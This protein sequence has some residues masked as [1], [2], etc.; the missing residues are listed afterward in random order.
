MGGEQGNRW[1]DQYVALRSS[2][3]LGKTWTAPRRIQK[4]PE[5]I[6]ARGETRPHIAFGN[7]GEIYI[8]YTSTIAMPH[9]GEIRFVRSTD[10]GQTFSAPVTVHARIGTSL[11]IAL[12][13][14]WSTGMDESI[15]YGSTAAMPKRRRS[16]RNAM[17]DRG[18]TMPSEAI[19]ERCS[20]ATTSLPTTRANA[21]G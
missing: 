9:I 7:K 14:S 13:R 17:P 4:A 16:A 19:R 12:N 11:C 18:F 15:L 6:Q 8:T 1:T 20:K 2:A 21:A 10:G 3:D 5:P